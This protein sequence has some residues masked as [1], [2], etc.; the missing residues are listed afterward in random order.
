MNLK[1]V[2]VVLALIAIVMMSGCTTEKVCGTHTE[3]KYY[4]STTLGCDK[5]QTATVSCQCLH[6]SWG[7]L[8]AC[9]S[10]NCREFI[11]VSNC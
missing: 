7:G 2:P 6:K 9:D 8:G 10:C 4:E 11:K 3:T 5:I 1:I